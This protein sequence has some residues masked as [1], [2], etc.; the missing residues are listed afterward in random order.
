ME[1]AQ[2]ARAV[3]SDENEIEAKSGM[4][5]NRLGMDQVTQVSDWA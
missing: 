3:S 1:K 4:I 2:I 5:Q